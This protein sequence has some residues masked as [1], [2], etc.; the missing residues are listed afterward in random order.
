MWER[1]RGHP[2]RP[3]R[4][5]LE[6]REEVSVIEVTAGPHGRQREEKQRKHVFARRLLG[7]AAA[8]SEGRFEAALPADTMHS[9][10]GVKTRLRWYLQVEVVTDDGWTTNHDHP[11][12]VRPT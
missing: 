12:I 1:P 5:W 7:D 6:G 8:L 2:A 11:V 4:L 10:S 9:F 3:F